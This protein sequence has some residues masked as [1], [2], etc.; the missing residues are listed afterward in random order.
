VNSHFSKAFPYL[1][2]G[3]VIPTRGINFDVGGLDRPELRSTEIGA[4]GH[5]R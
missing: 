4:R 2:P 5:F 3:P 1:V